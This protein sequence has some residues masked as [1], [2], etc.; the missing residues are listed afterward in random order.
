MLKHVA[1]LLLA[2]K[3]ELEQH[4]QPVGLG[5]LASVCARHDACGHLALLTKPYLEKILAGRKTIESRFSRARVP[6]F[7]R[8]KAGDVVFLKE[9]AGPVHA[10]A[11]ASY[12]QF[13]G[14]LGPGKVEHIMEKYRQGLQ[15]DSDFK[16][17][18]QD[19]LYATLISLEAVLPL[20]PLRVIKLD[21]RPWV[22]LADASHTN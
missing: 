13:F 1:P 14:P 11:L 8:V 20:K 6:P 2:L 19:S 18:K 7:N 21:R 10:I 5:T 16:I 17:A 15:L 4:E 9:V 12:V 22:V 3:E